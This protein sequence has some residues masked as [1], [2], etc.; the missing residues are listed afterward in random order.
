MTKQV[1]ITSDSAADLPPQ[2]RE[3]IGLR[4]VPL[5]IQSGDKSGLDGIG[6]L[7]GDIYG[8]FRAHKT[9]PKTAAPSPEELRVFFESFT[10]EGHA[11]VHIALN[12]KFSASC[13]NAVIAAQEAEGEVCV[14]DCLNFCAGQGML[15]AQAGRLRDEG[16]PAAEIAQT[17]I[18]LRE[19]VLGVYYLDALDFISR[20]GRCPGVVALGANL[21]SLHPAVHFDGATGTNYIGK[22]Y[23]G[24][25]AQA[26]EAW[27]RDAAQKFLDTCDPALCLL[28]RTP[29]IPPAVYEPIHSLAA[30]L[31]PGAG[32]LLA[33]PVGGLTVSHVGGGCFGL[34]GMAR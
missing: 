28:P 8:A 17:L 6:I 27:L 32:R 20:S 15:C 25:S 22:K 24:K 11:V 2:I 13:Q 23:R 5:H 3:E 33:F 4:T 18:R 14:V 7:P 29:D 12:S 31:L 10:R 30:Q 34:V 9:I 1:I 19:K 16:L 21:L 26:A